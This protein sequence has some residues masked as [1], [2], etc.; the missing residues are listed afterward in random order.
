MTGIDPNAGSTEQTIAEVGGRGGRIASVLSALA[1]AFSGLSFYESVLKTAALE[2]YVPPVI[3]YA[4]DQGGQIELFAIP[5]TIVNSGAR[6]GTALTMELTVENL[7]PDAPVKTKRYY[8]AYIG[9]HSPK[10]DEINR[11]F[12]PLSL[13]GRATF[14]D[15]VRFYPEGDA[16]PVLVD[17][18]GNYRFT[19]KLTTAV[20][21][22]AGPLDGLLRREIPPIAFER[23]LPWFSDQQLERRATI[24]M[25][26]KDWKPTTTPATAA[27]MNGS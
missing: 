7:R 6:T 8:S 23:A 24:P 20:P 4:R 1:L 25:H 18:V 27:K 2:V 10:D 19:L 26:D 17:D 12:A 22:Y 13:A 21:T 14:S 11:A 9:E 15:T 3:H 5:I 16:F